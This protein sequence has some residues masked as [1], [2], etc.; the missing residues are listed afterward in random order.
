MKPRALLD[1]EQ[2]LER[3]LRAHRCPPK[4]PDPQR[5][6]VHREVFGQ[7][8]EDFTT[9]KPILS[10][11]R[12]EYVALCDGGRAPS[13]SWSKMIRVNLRHGHTLFVFLL[14]TLLLK[15]IRNRSWCGHHRYEASLRG[16]RDEVNELRPLR[17]K[18][19]TADEIHAKEVA[20]VQESLQKQL[21]AKDVSLRCAAWVDRCLARAGVA[22]LAVAPGC[23]QPLARA[24]VP[25]AEFRNMQSLYQELLGEKDALAVQVASLAEELRKE[26]AKYNREK[27][28][29]LMLVADMNEL[30]TAKGGSACERRDPRHDCVSPIRCGMSRNLL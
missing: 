25:Q 23:F 24:T 6:Q 19:A 11:I 4:G 9:Y 18:L 28:A 8:I 15:L 3:E 26:A 12:A 1:L 13:S 7:L 21:V 29:R 10:L 14:R 20:A 27:A 16:L 5:L 22:P 2:M 30:R 17:A